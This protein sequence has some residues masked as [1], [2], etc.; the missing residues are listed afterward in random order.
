[1]YLRSRAAHR[2]G[3]VLGAG[4]LVVSGA[5]HLDLFLT[6]YRTIP[7]V[8]WLFL[9]QV[10]SAFALAAALL[11]S[12][13]PLVALGGAGLAA[14]TL[15]GYL[16]ALW[17]GVFGFREVP[18]T[19]GAASGIVDVAA[20]L[21]LGLVAVLSKGGV[22][23]GERAGATRHLAGV[24]VVCGVAA[25]LLGTALVS[26]GPTATKG[27]SVILHTRRIKGDRVLTTTTGMTLYW[28]SA[29]AGGRSRCY[30]SCASYWP[31][32]IGTASSGGVTG[33]V[34]TTKRTNGASQ[35]TYDGHPLYSYVGD[36]AAG[37]AN[38][39]GLDLNGGVWH[40]VVVAAS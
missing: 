11:I 25:V 18:T 29:D 38:G 9:A 36:S 40:E 7:T 39:N 21:V 20:V 12:G 15:G 5:I 23:L 13:S 10:V 8:G 31:P 16:L 19:A 4:L 32:L 26:E 2:S 1:M 34:G 28:F 14:G 24:A 37:Q 17:I 30:G 35:V 22:R 6:G 27:G 33:R 3:I